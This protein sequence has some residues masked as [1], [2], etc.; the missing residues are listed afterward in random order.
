[1]FHK[2]RHLELS[3][4]IYFTMSKSSKSVIIHHPIK[5][6]YLFLEKYYTTL[7]SLFR[8]MKTFIQM[9]WLIN[10]VMWFSCSVCRT[11]QAVNDLNI[12]SQYRHTKK[13]EIYW[14]HL[15]RAAIFNYHLIHAI[16]LLAGVARESNI[17]RI[18]INRI[19]I[20]YIPNVTLFA[21]FRLDYS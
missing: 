16:I 1:M 3:I 18:F 11:Y 19:H 4:Y 13:R 5:I 8:N 14:K 12:R 21:F 6:N 10:Y 20:E 7:R 9:I 15:Y 17:F 2:C